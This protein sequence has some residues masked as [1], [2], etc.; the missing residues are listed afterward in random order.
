MS[1]ISLATLRTTIRNRGDYTNVRRFPDSYLDTEIQNAFAKFYQLVAECNEGWW[2]TTG[3]ASTVASQAYVALPSDC[4]TVRAIDRLD[5]SDYREMAQ[6]GLSE[7]NRYG[8]STAKPL[9]Y[10]LSAR[11]I[12]LYPTPNAVYTLRVTYTPLAPIL[13]AAREW[14]NGWED[15]VIEE[16]LLQIDKR[17]QRPLGERMATID[18]IIAAVKSGASQRRRQEPEYLNL[19]E[20]GD[21]DPYGDGGIS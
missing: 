13:G 1:A 12:E 8:S 18:R 15:Y 19:R 16:A 11:G 14:Y 10:R 5:G 6:V 20:Y 7:R 2:D 9:A 4:W 17:E 3:S 21:L